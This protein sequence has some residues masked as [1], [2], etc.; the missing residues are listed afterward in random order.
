[1]KTLR[2]AVPG[3]TS[4]AEIVVDRHGIPHLRA[5][6]RPDLYFLQGFNAAR[7]RLWQL[8]I[9]RRRGLGLLA[10]A[11]GPGFLEQDRAARLFLYRGRCLF[12]V[13]KA[14]SGGRVSPMQLRIMEQPES[15]GIEAHVHNNV[16]K[17]ITTLKLFMRRRK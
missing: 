4:P 13:F 1:M 5:A 15:A 8:E 16:D 9:W 11:F 3:L 14:S 7:D 10:E 17:A 2:Y 6:G 12:I